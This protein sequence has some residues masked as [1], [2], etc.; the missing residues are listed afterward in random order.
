M[1]LK[2][3]EL[4]KIYR[5]LPFKLIH[6]NHK[7]GS[8]IIIISTIKHISFLIMYANDKSPLSVPQVI[9]FIQIVN[10]IRI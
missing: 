3:I 10:V 4:Y 7:P 8:K 6:S 5:L 2:L 9:T 1:F